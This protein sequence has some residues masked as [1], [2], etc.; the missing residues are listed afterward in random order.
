ML[1]INRYGQRVIAQKRN[2]LIEL[3][4]TFWSLYCVHLI[5]SVASLLFYL[6]YVCFVC[7]SNVSIA[8]IQL[9]YVSSAA[10]DITWLFYGLEIMEEIFYENCYYSRSKLH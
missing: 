8:L 10:F 6:M 2:D 9:L 3:R 7:N 1:G 4:R 5:A